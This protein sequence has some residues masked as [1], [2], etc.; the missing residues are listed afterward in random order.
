MTPTQSFFAHWYFHFPNLPMAALIYTLAGRYILEL[1]FQ[2]RQD[3]VILRVFRSVT[4]PILN[5]VRLVT[6]A[7]VPNG[8]VIVFAATWLMALRLGW[9]LTC[10]AAGMRPS[11][12][13]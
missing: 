13:V 5:T 12:G 3:V 6:P 7:I 11:V 8:L 1:L 4:D 9:F 2:K 10:V